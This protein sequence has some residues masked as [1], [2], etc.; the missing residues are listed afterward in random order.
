[1]V[2]YTQI[3]AD[4]VGA[5]LV[6]CSTELWMQSDPDERLEVTVGVFE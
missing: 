3:P 6:V 4:L 1:M 5:F 2:G